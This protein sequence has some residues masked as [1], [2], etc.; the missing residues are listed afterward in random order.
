M[1]LTSD[2]L[3]LVFGYF[4]MSKKNKGGCIY[5]GIGNDGI[6]RTC[7]I[8][9]HAGSRNVAPGTTHTMAKDLGFKNAI[10]LKEFGSAENFVYSPKAR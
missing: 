4:N 5:F 1:T 2:D 8:D 10:E 3:L 6:F 7:K 9:F